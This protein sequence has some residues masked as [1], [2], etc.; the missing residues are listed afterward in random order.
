[1]TIYHSIANVTPLPEITVPHSDK[2]PCFCTPQ[3]ASHLPYLSAENPQ[4][5]T[6]PIS[7]KPNIH[8]RAKA[9]S[10]KLSVSPSHNP[11][12]FYHSQVFPLP[13]PF[14]K[15]RFPILPLLTFASIAVAQKQNLTIEVLYSAP[16]TR[17]SKSGDILTVNYNGT[18]T[19]GT[20]FDS[21]S[22]SF[23]ISSC[24]CHNVS[25]GMFC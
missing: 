6:T 3:Q 12:P 1:M 2:F 23:P 20:L 11:V 21:S 13:P 22:C 8:S 9:Q 4:P 10:L 16:C 14:P 15:M 24:F 5:Q 18:L 7:H 25:L 17:S 19:D